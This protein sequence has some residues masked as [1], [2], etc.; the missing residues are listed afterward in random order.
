MPLL[1]RPAH[2]ADLPLLAQMNKR[3]IEDEGSR[4]PMSIDQ[5]A[6]RMQGWL[7]GDWELKLFAMDD[8]VVGYAVYQTR[9]DEYFSDQTSVYLR[10][11]YIERELR[12]QGLGRAAIRALAAEHF[13]LG[14]RVVIDVLASNPRGHDFWRRVGFEPYCTTMH[15]RNEA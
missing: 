11:F 10:Q 7:L 2:E 14:C 13:P 6:E 5:L 15:L 9:R 3:L 8:R 1:V 4:N 12:G